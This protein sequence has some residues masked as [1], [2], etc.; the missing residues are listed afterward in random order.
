MTNDFIYM[1]HL[2]GCGALGIMPEPPDF[3]ADWQQILIYAKEQE[4]APFIFCALR[5]VDFFQADSGQKREFENFSRIYMIENHLEQQEQLAFLSR[6][7][8]LGL[9][10]MVL[11]GLAMASC[12]STPQARMACDADIYIDPSRE[13]ELIAL[14]K[15]ED[16]IIEP[17]MPGSHHVACTHP[18]IGHIELHNDL[19]KKEISEVWFESVNLPE[20]ID[21]TPYK[22]TMAQRSFYSLN[23]ESHMSFVF[24]HMLKHFIL[25]GAGLKMCF[26]IW[27]FYE[28]HE[29]LIDKSRLKRLMKDCGGEGVWAA[30]W[31]MLAMANLPVKAGALN[32]VHIDR[33]LA[34]LFINDLKTGGYLG[35]KEL[36]ARQ[37]DAFEYGKQKGS[38]KGASAYISGRIKYYKEQIIIHFFPSKEDLRFNYPQY[39][40]IKAY[41]SYVQKKMGG[42][43]NRKLEVK[44]VFSGETV[45]ESR[46]DLMKKMGI[47]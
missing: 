42:F 44:Q 26:D 32:D 1:I 41:F 10:P 3:K 20:Y 8:E 40:L 17:L 14:L 18:K 6:A 36:L 35:H 13:Q 27:L 46:A 2:A 11:K 34:E 43:F 4:V 31:D 9:R 37:I 21:L 5:N 25:A 39:N 28:K 12:Y 7:E 19:I 47:L 45:P 15:E 38:S 22:M 16:A 33:G 29:D 24:L 30:I 23:P